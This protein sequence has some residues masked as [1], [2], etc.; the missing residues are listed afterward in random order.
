MLDSATLFLAA[1]VRDKVEQ[2]RD[3]LAVEPQNTTD[4]FQNVRRRITV[5]PLLESQVVLGA[6][7]GEH[8]DFLPAQSRNPPG[9]EVCDAHLFR[10]HQLAARPQELA[11]YVRRIGHTSR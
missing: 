5:S 2:I 4:G 8:G 10:C 6:D 9:A 7:T 11:Q 1:V 3:A